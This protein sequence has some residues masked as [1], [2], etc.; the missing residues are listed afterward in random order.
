MNTDSGLPK[1]RRRGTLILVAILFLGLG[2]A[3]TAA[4]IWYQNRLLDP[5]VLTAPE[6]EEI[7]ERIYQPGKKSFTLTER[8]LN[9][10][11]HDHT[12]LGQDVRL[13]LVTDALHARIRTILPP[14]FPI[15]GGHTLRARARFLVSEKG[16][17]LDDFTAYG[18]S[19]PNAWLGDLKG[20]ALLP[21]LTGGL[22]AGIQSLQIQDGRIDVSL[23]E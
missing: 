16:L 6:K 22:P 23:E 11:L 14:D 8:E 5:V 7:H 19:L 9:G 12:N 17:I 1:K 15:L 4:V 10:L 18:I 3:A 20:K 21:S 13:E 2:A